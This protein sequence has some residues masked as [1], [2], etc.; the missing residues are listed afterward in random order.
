MEHKARIEEIKIEIK[1]YKDLIL[2]KRVLQDEKDFAK[3][4]IIEL[5]KELIELYKGMGEVETDIF[6]NPLIF[7]E[8]ADYVLGGFKKEE[9]KN[10]EIVGDDSALSFPKL[11][12]IFDNRLKRAIEL[13]MESNEDLPSAL[14]NYLE[15]SSL[16]SNNGDVFDIIKGH[17]SYQYWLNDIRER[18]VKYKSKPNYTKESVNEN[19][20]SEVELEDAEH[21]T[22]T[23][24]LIE[25]LEQLMCKNQIK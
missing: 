6:Y 16:E 25:M 23:A 7:V 2:D 13:E 24:T 21:L 22:K 14:E 19:L 15:I 17:S 11:E 12:H 10:V 9:L 1:E 5:E 8:D 3:E 20:P 4:E 18:L